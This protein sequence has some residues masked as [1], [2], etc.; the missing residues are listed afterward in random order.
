MRKFFG[1]IVMGATAL[2]TL[3]CSGDDGDSSTTTATGSTGS[4]STTLDCS[5]ACDKVIA[6]GCKDDS[7]NECLAEC[8]SNQ[9]ESAECRPQFDALFGCAVDN[10]TCG[11]EGKATVA[12]KTLLEVCT[13]ELLA[14]EGCAACQVQA[15][16]S[17]CDQCR[18]K[19]CCDSAKAAL[20][21]PDIV[22]LVQCFDACSGQGDACFLAC[23]EK[24]P[25]AF[26]NQ[27]A[28]MTC[29]EESCVDECTVVPNPTGGSDGG[30]SPAGTGGA[31]GAGS[32][33]GGAGGGG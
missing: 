21:H 19:A 25:D 33:S 4:G 13:S 20:G 17:A 6:L 23:G 5:A 32:G 9:M 12:D 3:H 26:A 27:S 24:Y 14:V 11:M 1:L 16:D 30:G 15:N 28:Y 10:L 2:A 31:G 8:E 29:Q 7:K 22:A 18:A